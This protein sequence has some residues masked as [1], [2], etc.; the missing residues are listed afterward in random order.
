MLGTLIGMATVAGM[1]KIDPMSMQHGHMYMMGLGP[2]VGLEKGSSITYNLADTGGR[3]AYEFGGQGYSAGATR[4]NAGV[5]FKPL[6]LNKI[7]AETGKGTKTTLGKVVPGGLGSVAMSAIGPLMSAGFIVGGFK[8]N[9]FAGA[10]DAYF[11]DIATSRAMSAATFETTVTQGAGTNS[12]G[13]V[14]HTRRLGM[15]GSLG[16]GMGAFMG[17]EI[18]NQIAGVPG[19]FVGAT[20][21]SKAALAFGRNP[22]GMGALVL[23]GLAAKKAGEA[24]VSKIGHIVKKGYQRGKMRHRIDTAGST[25]AF[26][27]QNA[28]TTRGRAFEAMRKSHLN[29]R[30]ALGMEASMTHMNRSYF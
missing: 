2:A 5:D 8:E 20:M 25:A 9:G 4:A 18:G 10:M 15:L 19:G 7:S 28:I 11:L 26:F 6:D 14:T 13:T 23:G 21:G 3:M 24:V 12:L 27:T 29:A 17:Y 30:S 16:T 22:A 1:N